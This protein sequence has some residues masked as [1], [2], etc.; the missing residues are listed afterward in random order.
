MM[1]PTAQ[2]RKLASLVFS[3]GQ[4]R[5]ITDELTLGRADG[6]DV[7]LT[8]KTVSREHAYLFEREGRWFVEDLGSLNGTHLNGQ[9]IPVRTP[10]TLRH[11]DR[12]QLGAQVLVFTHP[13]E[14]LDEDRTDPDVEVV[15]VQSAAPQG[16]SALQLQVVRLLCEEWLAGGSLEELP[17]NAEIAARLGTP[18]ASETVKAAL[19]RAY[20]KA[21]VSGLP[22]HTKRR[23]L[24]RIAR[25]RGW[26]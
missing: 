5:E 2:A 16:L 21:G 24:C 10:L 3:D 25:H 18:D 17:S 13:A 8:S 9:R 26:L 12:L 6:N 4:E 19:R 7:V 20:A 14:A 15:E 23:A 1:R 22:A 11:G